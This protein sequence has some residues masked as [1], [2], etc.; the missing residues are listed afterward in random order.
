MGGVRGLRAERRAPRGARA[1]GEGAGLRE[2]AVGVGLAEVEPEVA[3][4]PLE[5]AGLPE[6]ARADGTVGPLA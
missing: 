1:S 5:H 2:R 4:D 6:A 3:P